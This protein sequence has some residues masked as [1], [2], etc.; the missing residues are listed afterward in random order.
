L[1]GEIQ[2]KCNQ[3]GKEFETTKYGVKEQKI[4]CINCGS[5]DVETI[6]SKKKK[7]NKNEFI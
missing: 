4:E 6:E 3:C 7:V 5:E 2:I 1:S